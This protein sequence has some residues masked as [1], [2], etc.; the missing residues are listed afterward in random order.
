MD[1]SSLK[2]VSKAIMPSYMKSPLNFD[3]GFHHR[4]YD[5][6]IAGD[7]LT[8]LKWVIAYYAREYEK[9]KGFKG[10]FNLAP[11]EQIRLEQ[12]AQVMEKYAHLVKHNA[13]I[14]KSVYGVD[15]MP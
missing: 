11:N 13:K 12:R 8:V 2:K 9:A 6:L 3:D 14:L 15:L 4:V 1:E 5:A 10:Y 7:Y